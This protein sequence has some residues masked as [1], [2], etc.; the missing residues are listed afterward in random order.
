MKKSKQYQVSQSFIAFDKIERFGGKIADPFELNQSN[1]EEINAR[2]F[3]SALE[4][5][6]KE[7]AVKL[8]Q[9]SFD[10]SKKIKVG[11]EKPGKKGVKAKRVLD[12]F[13]HFA[14][15]Q[16]KIISVANDE[17]KAL[18]EEK[19]TGMEESEQAEL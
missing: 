13:P 7:A 2:V 15:M 8:I 16:H 4:K 17:C 9:A 10:N 3:T 19:L 11:M 12:V 18:W 5:G 14:T 1:K 6:K